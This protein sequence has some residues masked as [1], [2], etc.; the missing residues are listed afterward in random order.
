MREKKKRNKNEN[1]EDDPK[2]LNKITKKHRIESRP[3][4][5]M[6]HNAV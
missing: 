6:K 4:K 5:V 2:R 1:K 3:K